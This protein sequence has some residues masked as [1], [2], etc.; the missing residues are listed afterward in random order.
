MFSQNKIGSIIRLKE[1]GYTLIE[2]LITLGLLA[3]LMMLSV[4]GYQ[5]I[6]ATI[7]ARI[8]LYRLMSLVQYAHSEAIRAGQ[9]VT[10]CKSNDGKTC[11]GEWSDGQ[12]VFINRQRPH[13]L[14]ASGRVKSG[15]LDFRAFQS[16]NFLQFMP[17]GTTFEQNGSFIYY[18]G[19][20]SKKIWTLI[21]EKC[22]RMRVI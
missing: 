16:S 3:F 5:G 1:E 8:A 18:S 17:S 15:K 10:I 11:S 20:A 9:R 2:L 21:I 6:K 13:I 7:D 19:A 4:P 14:F 12:I 22:G